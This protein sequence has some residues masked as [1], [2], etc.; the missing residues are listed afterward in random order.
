M[1]TF[2]AYVANCQLLKLPYDIMSFD[3][4][5][6]FEKVPLQKVIFELAVKGITGRAL[7]WFS[8][9]LSERTNQVR[10]RIHL[11]SVKEVTSSVVEGS[12]LGPDHSFYTV[13]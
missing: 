6:A 13:L 1:L 7:E 2:D 3:F 10:V 5:K 11:P 12:V 9:F 8:S 4:K